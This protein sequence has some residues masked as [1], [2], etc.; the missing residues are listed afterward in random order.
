MFSSPFPVGNPSPIDAYRSTDLGLTWHIQDVANHPVRG[1]N[2]IGTCVCPHP[3]NSALVTVFYWVTA[4]TNALPNTTP[5]VNARD[6]NIETGLWTGVAY[7]G[8]FPFVLS[9][10]LFFIGP[11][12]KMVVR[13]PIANE[14]VALAVTTNGGAGNFALEYV[15]LTPGGTWGV[16]IDAYPTVPVAHDVNVGSTSYVMA[17]TANES[18]YACLWS[19]PVPGTG[20]SDLV[21]SILSPANSVS[22]VVMDQ[23]EKADGSTYS[24]NGGFIA[25][26]N[27]I[28]FF[29]D[30]SS[31]PL[32]HE[33]VYGGWAVQGGSITA[34]YNLGTGG[35]VGGN[36]GLT[37]QNT[38]LSLN[39]STLYVWWEDLNGFG[40][41]VALDPALATP[42]V[43][44]VTAAAAI[45]PSIAFPDEV[46]DMGGGVAGGWGGTV[47]SSARS[48]WEA[49]FS[50][51]PPVVVVP[52][53]IGSVWGGGVRQRELKPCYKTG[54]D[55]SAFQKE[56]GRL[57]PPWV[58]EVRVPRGPSCSK[59]GRIRT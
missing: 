53:Q 39:Y 41:Y 45:F 33:I 46:H 52:T 30:F 47:L 4:P 3:T 48:Y 25:A 56:I 29:M 15:R 13:R 18:V 12:L 50:A 9:G 14:F 7:G 35:I 37:A 23:Y 22:T 20:I 55:L 6:F 17:V 32:G 11:V 26:S 19:E 44:P 57:Q 10:G 21:Q 5:V 16:A 42:V 2:G 27:K 24:S 43:G 49:P 51:A 38:S 36:G 54:L 34:P 40:Y 1:V 58:A 8:T 31:V 59:S 28:F